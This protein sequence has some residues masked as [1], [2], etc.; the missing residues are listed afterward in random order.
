MAQPFKR[1]PVLHRRPGQIRH[2]RQQYHQ[3]RHRSAGPTPVECTRQLNCCDS[4]KRLSPSSHLFGIHTTAM[5]GISVRTLHFYDE[6]VL[7]K[8]AYTKANSYRIYEEPQQ[9]VLQQIFLT[10]SW[11]S[12]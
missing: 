10:E 9:L 3:R 1:G 11:A 6:M 5:S 4:P 12:S 7:L 8:P 2:P